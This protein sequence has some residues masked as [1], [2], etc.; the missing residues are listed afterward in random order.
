MINQKAYEDE[1]KTFDACAYYNWR[2]DWLEERVRQRRSNG[3]EFSDEQYQRWWDEE[4]H[5]YR[6]NLKDMSAVEKINKDLCCIVPATANHLVYLK[7]CIE[8]LN[9]TGYHVHLAFDNPFHQTNIPTQLKMPHA[10]IFMMV[11]S[12]FMKHKTWHSGVGVPHAWN[13][14]YGLQFLKAMGFKYVFNLNGDCILERPEGV[15]EI[16]Q[17][18]K[19]EDAD[20]ITCE[21]FPERR[22]AG[23]MSWLSKMDLAHDIWTEYMDELY[24]ARGNGEA[25]FGQGIVKRNAKWLPVE[26]P[27]D[28][29]FKPPGVKGTWRTQLGLRHLHAEYKVRRAQHMEPIEQKYV[30]PGP[31]MLYFNGLER[32]VFPE[33]WKTGN[34][35]I[36]EEGW[37][38]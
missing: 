29:H 7:A 38:L 13:M 23:T 36:I 16:F 21:Y 8:S 17:Q 2:L 24:C 4:E 12:F 5:S 22:Y 11:D 25:R 30:D 6:N 31:D 33:Y 37:W 20:I 27:E 10:E 35:K 18:L 19:D 34:M 1:S 3:E 15:E 9:K 26:N 28:S 32:K 14:Y